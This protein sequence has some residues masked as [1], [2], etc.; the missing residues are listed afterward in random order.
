LW[1]ANPRGKILFGR[2][3]KYIK[4]DPQEVG[5]AG[6][7]GIEKAR[8]MDRWLTFQEVMNFLFQEIAANIL[9]SCKHVRFSRKTLLHGVSGNHRDH[10]WK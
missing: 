4:T 6:M 1:Q 7:D 2:R 9:N 3:E 8:N 5:C 10:L